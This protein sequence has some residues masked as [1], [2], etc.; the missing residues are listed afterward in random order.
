VTTLDADTFTRAVEIHGHQ[1][2]CRHE[3]AHAAAAMVQ[4]LDVDS[5]RVERHTLAELEHADLD[6]PAGQ[7]VIRRDPDRLREMAIV[8]IAGRLEEGDP[9][10]PPTRWPMSLAPMTP[11]E[12]SLGESVVA[13]GL[14]EK[15]Y[16]QLVIDAYQLCASREY[17]ALQVAIEHALEIHGR[18]DHIALRRIKSIAE[19]ATVEHLTLKAVTT[20]STD[21]GVFEAVISTEGVDR[22]K[23]IVSAAGMVAALSKWNRPIP[24]AWNH[25][26]DAADIFGHI[27]P[28]TVREAVGEVVAG[29]QVHLDSDVGREAWRS[30]KSRAIGF[31]F[32]YLVP[33]GGATPRPGGG[34]HITALD[35]FE[36]TA[37][38]TPMNND[39]RVLS[40][41]ALDPDL[42]A[43]R[44]EWRDQMMAVLGAST[45]TKTVESLR[46]KSERI[47]RECA[48]IQIATFDA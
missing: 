1:Q 17:E 8:T 23:D 25:R 44:I 48:P 40:T 22:E 5:A 30:F 27:H 14:D 31:S 38:P 6:Q 24:L 43:F 2:L 29:G 20:V 13:L 33:D 12:E 41:K 34:R 45:E 7:V 26:S 32:G 28:E 9:T 36:I 3:A 11:D 39:T 15:G 46:A 10:W 42:E 21:Q 16:R 47:A 18:L 19:G 4:G 37:T 35:V